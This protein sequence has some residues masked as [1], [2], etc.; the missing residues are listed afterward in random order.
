M[1]LLRSTYVIRSSLSFPSL[2]CHARSCLLLLFRLAV[3]FAALRKHPR[4]Y[5]LSVVVMFDLAHLILLTFVFIGFHAHATTLN[6]I[7]NLQLYITIET[8]N[9]CKHQNVFIIQIG[10]VNSCC[11]FTTFFYDDVVVNSIKIQ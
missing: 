11:T 2:P 6:V 9:N 1:I 10:N 4:R 8:C 7:L 3:S 5:V